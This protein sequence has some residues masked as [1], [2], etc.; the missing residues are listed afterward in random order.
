MNLG[1]IVAHRTLVCGKGK[2]PVV[3]SIGVPVPFD[4]GHDYYCP[5]QITGLSSVREGRAGGVDGVQALILALQMAAADLYTSEEWKRGD[6]RFLGARELDLPIPD[7]IRDAIA[8][9]S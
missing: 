4:D 9:R 6:L 7:S 2:T 8:D 3:I 1:Q 5:Y